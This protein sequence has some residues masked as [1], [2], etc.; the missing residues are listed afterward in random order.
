[1]KDKNQRDESEVKIALEYSNNIIATLREPFLVLD[2]NLRVIS[3]NQSFYTTFEVAEKD[4]IGRPL[5]DLGDRQWNIPKLLQLLKEIIPE[6]KVVKDYEVEYKFEQ[7]GQR[8]MI[9]NACQL[10]IP[11]KIAAIIAAGTAASEEGELILLAIEDITER[12]KRE[13]ELRR[14]NIE[15]EAFSY[16]VAHDLRAPLRSMEGFSQALME[17][18]ADKLDPQAKDYLQRVRSAAKVMAQLIDAMLGLSHIGRKGM[19]HTSVDLSLM[20]KKIC[21]DLKNSE[22]QRNAEFIIQDNVIVKGDES[23]LN[24]ALQNLLANA[25]KFTG[26]HKSARIEFGSLNLKGEQVYFVRDDGAGFDMAY[27][28]KLFGTFQRLHS[29]DEFSGIGIG[30][31]TVERI[32]SRHD[33]RIRAESEV[34][35]GAT[36]YFTLS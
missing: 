5:P 34:E 16:S 32:I 13:E 4:T 10:R 35:K 8:A 7:I 17:G 20:V 26:K 11:K 18:W 33:G 1:M 2:K 25:W 36:F 24:I 6:K 30:L 12:R 28:Q 15:L 27:S 31:V 3:S 21:L 29:N 9:L 19:K 23:L 14:L 22:P